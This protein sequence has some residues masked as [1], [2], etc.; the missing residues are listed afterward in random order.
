MGMNTS[1]LTGSGLWV[2]AG[3]VCH[4]LGRPTRM[5]GLTTG[6]SSGPLAVRDTTSASRHLL[7]TDTGIGLEVR[8]DHVSLPPSISRRHPMKGYQQ[9]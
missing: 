2:V 1:K 5:L 7:S 9:A 3:L 4:C 6:H 8:R